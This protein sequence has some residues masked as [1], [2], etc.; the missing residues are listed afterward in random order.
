MFELYFAD[1]VRLETPDSL[2]ISGIVIS[3]RMGR[4]VISV[5]CIQPVTMCIV[6]MRLASSLLIWMLWHHTDDANSV[7]I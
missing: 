4:N 7:S 2:W 3:A 6:L 1:V 5:D